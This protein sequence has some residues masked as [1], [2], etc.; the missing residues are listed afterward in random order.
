M[1]DKARELLGEYRK[2][3]LI[4]GLPLLFAGLTMLLVLPPIAEHKAALP[5]IALWPVIIV[6]L[7]VAIAQIVSA[8]Y[9]ATDVGTL[10][11]GTVGALFLY[12]LIATFALSG[13]A[14]GVALFL[15][16][17]LISV[18]L[19]YLYV[20]NIPDTQV[21]IVYAFGKYSR[22]LESGFNVVL[23]WEKVTKRLSVA[24]KQWAC[25]EQRIQM[26]QQDQD[27][28][29]RAVVSYQLMP[30]DAYLAAKVKNWEQSLRE[31][32]IAQL[33]TVLES[34][35]PQDLTPWSGNMGYHA[36][37]GALGSEAAIMPWEY[38][39]E[40]LFQPFSDEVAMWGVQVYSVRLR[41]V[42]MV[43][44]GEPLT[45][46]AQVVYTSSSGK[47]ADFDNDSTT[48]SSFST[49]PS[50]S[51][52]TPKTP[53]PSQAPAQ[54]V[55]PSSDKEAASQEKALTKLYT[56]VQSGKI[57]DPITIRDIAAK[58]DAVAK[59]AQ[60]NQTISFDVERAARNLYTEAE[61]CAQ[62]RH[63]Q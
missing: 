23:P 42:L 44:H 50:V 31:R 55:Q 51:P 36:T 30:R 34:F 16:L 24:E 8:Y 49:Q 33:Q 48:E 46:V 43:P 47:P 6:I 11:A 15:A 62:Q 60:L 28:V 40:E 52:E 57:T 41:D 4:V 3:L 14:A 59:D 26:S 29:A 58:F 19:W 9:V 54:S 20:K 1:I 53:Q 27:V 63:G 32:F 35:T 7:I 2:Y 45:D 37:F 22:T 21:A 13:L 5:P 10:V 38:K 12:L 61:K 25:P 17:V 18:A 56:E 39:N